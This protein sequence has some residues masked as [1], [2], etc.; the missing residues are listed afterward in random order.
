[1]LLTKVEPAPL[2]PFAATN[3]LA[4]WNT[5]STSNENM[6]KCMHLVPTETVVHNCDANRELVFRIICLGIVEPTT[7]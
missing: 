6:L 1:M 2:D 5:C 4:L 3:D 7:Q